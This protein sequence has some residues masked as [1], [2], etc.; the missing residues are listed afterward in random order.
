[1]TDL[2]PGLTLG[3]ALDE[4]QSYIL[5]FKL[6]GTV[7]KGDVVKFSAHTAGELPAVVQATQYATNVLGVALK[8]GVSGDI[9]PVLIFGVVKVTA[10]GAITGGVLVVAGATGYVE[11]I[12]TQTHEKVIGK[13]LQTFGDGDTGL[14]HILLR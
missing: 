12:G 4:S 7:A 2:F 9:I 5:P 6:G 8:A 13:A 10:S 11:T 14:V 3:E 1:M